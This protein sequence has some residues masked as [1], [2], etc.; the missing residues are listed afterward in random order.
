M[1]RATGCLVGVVA[2]AMLAVGGCRDRRAQEAESARAG[3]GQEPGKARVRCGA[4]E[5]GEGEVCCNPSCGICTVADG[6][7]T[8]QFCDKGADGARA[9]EPSSPS[10]ITCDNVRCMAGTHCE[11]VQVQCVRAPCDPVPRCKTDEQ[12]VP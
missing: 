4:N 12:A 9:G 5:C 10:A 3:A 8:Q 11:L 1:S 2:L 6:M 7:C